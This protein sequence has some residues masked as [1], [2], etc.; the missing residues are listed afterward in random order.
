[1]TVRRIRQTSTASVR[2]AP[3]PRAKALAPPAVPKPKPRKAA[4]Q[5]DRPIKPPCAPALEGAL[6]AGAVAPNTSASVEQLFR[7]TSA[8][9]STTAR[10]SDVVAALN[11]YRPDPARRAQLALVQRAIDE[12]GGPHIMVNRSADDALKLLSSGGRFSTLFDRPNPSDDVKAYLEGRLARERRL[13]T[14]GVGG[15]AG[16]T[17]YG[18]VE[19]SPLRLPELFEGGLLK[20]AKAKRPPTPHQLNTGISLTDGAVTFVLKQEVNPRSTFLPEDTYATRETGPR[21]VEHMASVVLDSMLRNADLYFDGDKAAVEKVFKL[22]PD[23]AVRTIKAY[24]TSGAL[25]RFY[26]EAQ[27]RAPTA[28]DVAYVIIRNHA[29]ANR[30]SPDGRPLSALLDEIRSK[31]GARGLKVV[32]EATFKG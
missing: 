26:L 21:A 22:A 1:M 11:A 15:Q 20:A 19:F 2:T 18:S 14:H 30:T 17:V 7:I 23:T 13:G 25:D 5:V 10:P 31:A 8:P 16:H 6:S 27:V 32:D 12:L 9:E 29:N 24:L 4:D 28:D 3:A